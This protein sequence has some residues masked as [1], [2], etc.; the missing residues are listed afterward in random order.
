MSGLETAIR[1][2]LDRSERENAESRA[3]IYQSARQALETGLRKQAINDEETISVQRRRLETLIHSIELE[4]RARLEALATAPEFGSPVEQ[5]SGLD[6][7]SPSVMA[8]ERREPSFAAAEAPIRPDP[9]GEL[10][11]QGEEPRF[12][13]EPSIDMRSERAVPPLPAAG[14]AKKGKVTT[15]KPRRRRSGFFARLFIYGTLLAALG[16]G[17]WWVYSSG[18]MLSAEDRDLSIPNPPPRIES[19][20]FTDAS[21]G[22]QA[23]DSRGGFS[24]DW[25]DVFEPQQIAA[26]RPRANSLVDVVTASDGTAV[27]VLSRSG[28]AAGAVEITVPTEVLREMAGRTS[29]IALTLQSTDNEPVQWSVSCDFSRL[30]DCSRRRFTANP[31]K[32]DALF[33]VSFENGMAP[34]N[35]GRLVINGDLSGGG[36]GVNLYS[37]RILPGQ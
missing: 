4:E 7:A 30:G 32:S 34:A 12:A 33:R 9:R 5:P 3:R 1:N 31:Q 11:H 28:D 8:P 19:E 36:R 13:D 20:D 16:T 23:I 14:R 37:V 15:E 25:I 35:P 10:H 21:A 26:I 29:T 6:I 18:F 17:A 24:D 22:P 27:R 2:A